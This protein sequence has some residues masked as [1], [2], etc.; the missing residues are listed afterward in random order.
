MTPRARARIARRRTIIA[1]LAIAAISAFEVYGIVTGSCSQGLT[2]TLAAVAGL[3]G[4][5]VG[6]LLQ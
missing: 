4:V 1:V 2:A 3:G 5:S 6:K